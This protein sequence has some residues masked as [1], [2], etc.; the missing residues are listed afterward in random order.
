[1]LKRITN[2]DNSHYYAIDKL[3]DVGDLLRAT[4]T[5]VYDLISYRSNME[6]QCRHVFDHSSVRN[7]IYLVYNWGTDDRI[8]VDIDISHLND[9]TVR[10]NLDNFCRGVADGAK[11][12][13]HSMKDVNI[14][15]KKYE[16]LYARFE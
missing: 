6:V 5:D 9:H 2:E 15:R 7:M 4:S 3:N 16:R 11:Y 8:Y 14:F 1:M 13:Y 10:Q 12:I